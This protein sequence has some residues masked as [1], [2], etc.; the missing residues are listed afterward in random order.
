MHCMMLESQNNSGETPLH[1]AAN[2][3][4]E[5]SIKVLFDKG[6]DYFLLYKKN[7]SEIVISNESL[8]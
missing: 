6:A 4:E 7:Y 5:M 3:N 2:L 1:I 8:I